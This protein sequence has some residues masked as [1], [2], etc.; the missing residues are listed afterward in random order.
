VVVVLL[1]LAQ[2]RSAA[3]MH[4]SEGILPLKW[5]LLWF[6]IAV[7]FVLFG[8]HKLKQ[9]SIQA[10][11]IKAFM[12]MVGAAV[13]LISAMPIPIPIA[14]SCSHPAGT[15]IAAILIGPFMTVVITSI[16]LLVQALFMAHGGLTTWGAD[17][18]SMGVV[19]AF[20][21]Y[22]VFVVMRK[23]NFPLLIA[24]FMAGLVGDWA[25]Y[26]T[27]SV[28]LATALHG[29][30][31][32]GSALVALILAFS[33]TQVPLGILEGFMSVGALSFLLKRRPDILKSLGTIKNLPGL[34]V[35]G[36]KA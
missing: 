32:L 3:A 24:A 33:P 16:A 10:P 8:I 2:P 9:R 26:A 5:A 12:G 28:E 31:P 1:L 18:M 34:T 35:K 15:G 6:A 23:F 13:F 14:G 25:T 30:A 20:S 7:P 21:G 11:A 4:L 17:V 22:Y 19:G 27:T 36:A 29:S